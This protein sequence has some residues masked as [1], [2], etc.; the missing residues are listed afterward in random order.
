LCELGDKVSRCDM[1][2]NVED[3]PNIETISNLSLHSIS[4][5]RE[6]DIS[7]INVIILLR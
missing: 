6:R 5:Q 2:L 7:Y 1:N 3:I 4:M